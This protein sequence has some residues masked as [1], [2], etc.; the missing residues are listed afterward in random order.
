[1]IQI[2]TKSELVVEKRHEV[3]FGLSNARSVKNKTSEIADYIV[4][5]DLNVTAITETWLG[6]LGS[7]YD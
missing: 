5:N 7:D 3:S 6:P 4:E 1:M 2:D